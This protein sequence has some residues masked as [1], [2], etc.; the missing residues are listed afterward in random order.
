MAKMDKLDNGITERNTGLTP[1]SKVDSFSGTHTTSIIVASLFVLAF[2][3][4][5]IFLCTI[6]QIDQQ[7]T[8]LIISGFFSLLSL[9]AGFFAGSK[10]KPG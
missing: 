6:K 5:V 1:L 2:I 10:S 7:M 4:F 3:G 9:L 8:T